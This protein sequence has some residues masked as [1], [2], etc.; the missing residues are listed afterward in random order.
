VGEVEA[1]SAPV[2][3]LENTQPWVK[4][5]APVPPLATA[6]VPVMVERVEVALLNFEKKAE[7][8]Q[9]KT[10]AEA[11]SQVVLPAAYVRPEE[12]VVVAT[13][14]HVPPERASICPSTPAKR[15]EVATEAA[16]PVAPVMFPSTEF[17]AT[18]ARLAK[19]RSPVIASVSARSSAPHA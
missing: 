15:E 5:V 7:V 10:E 4:T 16:S 3:P 1:E 17:A 8:R 12:K 13:P 19:G 18:C 9:P 14:V 11:L 2:P 6:S